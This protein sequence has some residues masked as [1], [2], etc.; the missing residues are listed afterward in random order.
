MNY[1]YFYILFL[2]FSLYLSLEN[3]LFHG[4]F[5]KMLFRFALKDCLNYIYYLLEIKLIF[6][7]ITLAFI[8]A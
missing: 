1:F 6:F 5:D 3:L 4:P 7:F 8:K 2:L